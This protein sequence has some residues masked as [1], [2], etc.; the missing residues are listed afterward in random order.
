MANR[1]LLE[2]LFINLLRN[3]S[4]HGSEA[5]LR[6]TGDKQKLVF[7]NQSKVQPSAHMTHA[8]VKS[9]TSRGVG[10]GLYLVARI[11]EHF[12]WNFTVEHSEGVFRAIIHLQNLD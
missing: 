10:Q 3:V 6:V 5:V 9:L 8:G 2:L 1:R 4:E 7:E 12:G 11:A